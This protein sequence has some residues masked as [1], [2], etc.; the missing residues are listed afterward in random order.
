[1]NTNKSLA[2]RRPLTFGF[3][4]TIVF[5]LLVLISSILVGRAAAAETPAWYIGSTVGRLVS[6]F[7]L[8]IVLARLG[9]L[10]S[11]G[12]TSQGQRWTWLLLLLPLVYSIAASAYAMTGNFDLSFSDPIFTGIVTLFLISHAFLEET[13]F[14]G[15]IMHSFVRAWSGANGVIRGVLVSSLFFGVMH[16]VY[17]AGEPLQVVLFRI[18][19][20]FLLGIF[21]SGLV[22]RGGSIYPA[23]FFHGLLNVAGYLNI[24]SNGA[25]GTP[26]PWLLLSLSM[27]PLA[28]YGLYLLRNLPHQFNQPKG[29]YNEQFIV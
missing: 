3:L 8:L 10:H 29:E 25:E 26:S 21:F 23:A 11:A 20:A 7:I 5:V 19:V 1:M 24:T 22:L 17:L 9:W 27:L 14:R 6:I 12:F 18:I 15:L 16:I 2:T 13:A 4:V 28:V